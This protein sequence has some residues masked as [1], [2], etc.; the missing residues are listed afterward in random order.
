MLLATSN[1]GNA[2]I[3]YKDI[4]QIPYSQWDRFLDGS[5]LVNKVNK[6]FNL[7][8]RDIGDIPYRQLCEELAN[9]CELSIG[10]VE[11][12][13]SEGIIITLLKYLGIDD[14]EYNLKIRRDRHNNINADIQMK[15]R[16]SLK[17]LKSAVNENSQKPEK[18]SKGLLGMFK[19]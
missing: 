15:N 14:N 7:V 6:I 16:K 2:E 1:A 5:D 19:R 10:A 4:S 11:E 3:R 9:N 18:Q 13:I 17:K 8:Y 12:M